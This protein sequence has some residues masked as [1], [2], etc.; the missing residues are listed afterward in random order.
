MAATA[1]VSPI[2]LAQHIPTLLFIS[3]TVLTST[4]ISRNQPVPYIDE[5]FHIPQAQRLC[6][7]LLSPD[8]IT[9]SVW[10]R[11]RS[12]EYDPKLTTPPGLYAISLALAKVLPGWECG[13]V[14]W[15]RSTNLVL[16]LTMPVLVA[17]TLR[18]NDER[19]GGKAGRP[20]AARHVQQRSPPSRKTPAVPRA[21]IKDLQAKAASE[22]PPTPDASQ[23]SLP[24][25]DPSTIPV[26]RTAP[27][28][29]SPSPLP[30]KP[31]RKEATPY[32][33]ALAS[34]ICF[35]PPLWFFGFLYYTDIAS[36]WLTLAC[37]TLY[38]DLAASPRFLTST[39]IAAI[40]LLAVMV[41]QTNIVWVGFCAAQ[42][43]LARI[44]MKGPG[45]VAELSS[46]LTAAFGRK[47]WQLWRSTMIMAA[48]MVPMLVGCAAFIRWNGSI[49]LGDKSNH[50]AGIH[51]PQMGYFLAFA[52]GFGVFPLLFSLIPAQARARS[53]ATLSAL[54]GSVSSAAGVLLKATLGSATGLITLA[55]SLAAF[56]IAVDRFTIDHPF[57]LAD[58]RHYTFYIWRLFRRTYPF[59]GVHIQPRY[60]MVPLYSLALVAWSTALS[61]N[62]GAL[63]NALFWLA[64]MATLIPTPLVEPRYFLIPYI[65]LRISCQP[66]GGEG[67]IKW[68]SLAGEVAT[69]A[70]VNVGTV[71]LFVRKPFE[72]APEAVDRG[73][74]EGTTMRFIW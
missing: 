59:A 58:N 36:V 71:A 24:D 64:T 12:V 11:L 17:R 72:W 14:A 35:L 73:R 57:L 34:T 50:Q 4:L 8:K 21:L 68:V 16:L 44:P 70:L 2:P 46:L 55:A 74:G 45:L 7:A 28:T 63:G 22:T 38:N 18:Q 54:I 33:M 40:S 25:I 51:L 6:S 5:I 69:Y 52:T 15:L 47:R 42:A 65:V 30:Q 9:A 20:N 48:P 3:V 43:L 19:I 60:A 26:T 23:D 62:Q 29:P 41:R 56:Y 37:W 66:R 39:L 27:P 61:T 53:N 13:D 1:R 32:T 67:R 31:K 49:V 10:Q